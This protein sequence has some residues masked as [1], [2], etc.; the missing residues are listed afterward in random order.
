MERRSRCA[1]IELLSAARRQKA[2]ICAVLLLFVLCLLDLVRKP[3]EKKDREGT[4]IFLGLN[5]LVALRYFV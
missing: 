1:E 4:H 5:L 2:V 3:A